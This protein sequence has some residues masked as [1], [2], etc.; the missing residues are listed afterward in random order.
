MLPRLCC[1]LPACKLKLHQ[2]KHQ[3]FMCWLVQQLLSS[4]WSYGSTINKTFAAELL[5]IR[6]SYRLQLNLDRVGQL[7]LNDALCLHSEQRRT[8]ISCYRCY[9]SIRSTRWSNAVKSS[10]ATSHRP[11]TCIPLPCS[12]ISLSSKTR[13][14]LT[15]TAHRSLDCARR[16]PT[17]TSWIRRL[18]IYCWRRGASASSRTSMRCAKLGWC[19]NASGRRHFRVNSSCVQRALPPESSRYAI[20]LTGSFGWTL[21]E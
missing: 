12:T 21:D 4:V 15:S 7:V 1:A 6:W 8:S 20:I 10:C 14:W 9:K 2:F 17:G 3:S 13:R 18:S 11:C 5:A 19:W 16:S